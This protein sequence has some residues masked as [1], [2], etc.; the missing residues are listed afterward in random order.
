LTVAQIW[1][2]TDVATPV[3]NAIRK[4]G[5]QSAIERYDQLIAR[6]DGFQFLQG[7]REAIVQAM[8]QRQG[9]KAAEHAARELGLPIIAPPSG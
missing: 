8:L 6:Q 3:M 9:L 1:F 5:G 2:T 7:Q 4:I